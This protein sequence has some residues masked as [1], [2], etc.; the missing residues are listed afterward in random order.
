MRLRIPDDLN[1]IKIAISGAHR[2]INALTVH[3]KF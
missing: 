2:L 1:S 3:V